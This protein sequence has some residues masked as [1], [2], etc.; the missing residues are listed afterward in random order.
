MHWHR[1]LRCVAVCVTQ[2][3][4]EA[5]WIGALGFWKEKN[6]S[7]SSVVNSLKIGSKVLRFLIT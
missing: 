2:D 6:K 4:A 5:D 3:A 7:Y 1:L